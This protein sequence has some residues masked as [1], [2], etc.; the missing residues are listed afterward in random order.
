MRGSQENLELFNIPTA[1]D[2]DDGSLIAIGLAMEPGI[3]VLLV[4][5]I[6]INPK[7]DLPC[8]DFG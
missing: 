1:V 5:Q 8:V 6:F 3:D 2:L 4:A 7:S